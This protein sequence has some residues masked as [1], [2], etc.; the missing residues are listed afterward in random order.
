MVEEARG[1][2]RNHGLL[3]SVPRTDRYIFRSMTS[4]AIENDGTGVG[5]VLGDYPEGLEADGSRVPVRFARGGEGRTFVLVIGADG[6]QSRTQSM[7]WGAE[8]KNSCRNGR[9]K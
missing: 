4:F 7:V 3:V 1:G 6:L 8:G 9:S 2:R 5:Y